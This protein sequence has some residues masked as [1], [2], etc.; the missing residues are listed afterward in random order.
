MPRIL[1]V[2]DD[3][4][5]RLVLIEILFDAG[6]E[7][8]A[9]QSLKA[10]AAILDGGPRFDLVITDYRLPDGNGMALVDKARRCSTPTLIITGDDRDLDPEKYAVLTKPMRPGAFLAAVRAALSD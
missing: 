9:A 2:E 4:A 3:T 6:Y 7:V 10:G 5:V 8:D 1:L